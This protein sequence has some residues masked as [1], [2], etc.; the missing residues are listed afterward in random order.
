MGERE[1]QKDETSQS[2]GRKSSPSR[3]KQLCAK[4]LRRR[5]RR[6]SPADVSFGAGT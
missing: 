4:A 3:A 5:A 6:A 1:A 2:P